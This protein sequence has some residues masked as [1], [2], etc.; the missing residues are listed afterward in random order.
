MKIPTTTTKNLK[1]SSLG[2]RKHR[3]ADLQEEQLLALMN[4]MMKTK[5]KKWRTWKRKKNCMIR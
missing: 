2:K 5:M 4:S 3:K 1:L